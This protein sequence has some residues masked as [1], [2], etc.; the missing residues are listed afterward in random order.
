MPAV[1]SLLR[2]VNVGGH[3]TIKMEE[4][5]CLYASL[6]LKDVQSYLQSGNIVFRTDETDLAK[7]A[8]RIQT[9]IE[10]RF[11]INPEVLLR[12]TAE[13]RDVIARNPF[14]KRRNLEPN[15]LLVSF[16]A[17]KIDKTVCAQ[18]SAL[19][20]TSEELIPSGRELFIYFANGIGKSKLPWAKV[21]KICSTS[22]TG[23]NWNSV[24]RLLAMAEAIESAK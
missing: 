16:L 4:L 17:A 18:L 5:R 23:R 22:G 3:S 11:G 8:K 15:K 21:E 13:M 14:A 9:A 7:L 12:T 10:K 24:T 1:I 20:L 19:P 6:K 2:A